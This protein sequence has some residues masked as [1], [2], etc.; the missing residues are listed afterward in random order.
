[1]LFHAVAKVYVDSY[2]FLRNIFIKLM[3][4]F[5]FFLRQTV[6]LG[7]AIFTHILKAPMLLY[8]QNIFIL[9]FIMWVKVVLKCS[10][11]DGE[12]KYILFITV[13]F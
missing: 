10:E 1:M 7:F 9:E 11:M 5:Y 13:G 4:R 3:L 8:C 12:G 6:S 2:Q